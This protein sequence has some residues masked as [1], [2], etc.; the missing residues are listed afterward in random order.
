SPASTMQELGK[1][2]VSYDNSILN[3]AKNV[4]KYTTELQRAVNLGVYNIDMCYAMSHDKGEDVLKY[5]KTVVTLSDAM[6][7]KGAVN[8]MI[9]KRA[10]SN[11]GNTDSL[12]KIL[13]E[14]FVKSDD[15]LRTNDRVLTAAN[16]FTGGWLEN[17]YI[18]CE[19]SIKSEDA[20]VKSK[21][22]N[23]LWEQRFHLG[24]IINMLN[25]HKNKKEAA[26][27]IAGL[28][29]IHDEINAVKQSKDM[30]EA[31]FKNISDKII[32]LRNK[33]TH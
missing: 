12:F 6:G 22:N 20:T 29:P 4:S 30:D 13:D 23:L 18:I 33:F 7:L 26:E 2:N 21:V 32:G 11:L 5:M 14:I 28:K 25:D 1:W 24:N 15:Y 10:E 8:G 9:G 3:D 19:T 16:V 27:L 17:L 31:K